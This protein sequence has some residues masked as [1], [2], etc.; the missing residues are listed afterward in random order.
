MVGVNCSP[1]PNRDR[2]N[3]SENLD[4]PVASLGSPAVKPLEDIVSNFLTSGH[5]LLLSRD[6]P[7]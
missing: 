6:Q 2:V 1:S 5:S 7:H 3:I 4:E